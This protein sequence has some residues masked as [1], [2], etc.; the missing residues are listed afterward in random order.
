MGLVDSKIP[1]E[2]TWSVTIRGEF[3]SD[4]QFF[5]N[6]GGRLVASRERGRGGWIVY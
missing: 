5:K 1:L 6:C 2:K 3:T 4:G